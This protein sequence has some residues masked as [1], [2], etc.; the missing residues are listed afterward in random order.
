ML[1]IFNILCMCVGGAPVSDTPN[2][3]V[4]GDPYQHASASSPN[5]GVF[6]VIFGNFLKICNLI[7]VKGLESI[8]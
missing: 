4:A 2:S 7:Q 5:F 3:D 1:G 6:L 8:F